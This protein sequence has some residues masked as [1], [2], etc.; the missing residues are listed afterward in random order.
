[1]KKENWKSRADNFCKDVLMSKTLFWNNSLEMFFFFFA[2]RLFFNFHQF[3][4][5]KFQI[6]LLHALEVLVLPSQQRRYRHTTCK[7]SV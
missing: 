5:I 3:Q 4:I 2:N 6:N 7:I 1:M